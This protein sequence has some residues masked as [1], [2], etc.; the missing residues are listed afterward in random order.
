M[1][2]DPS[3]AA[4]T[5]AFGIQ[6]GSWDEAW[7]RHF[8]LDPA[9]FPE[10]LPAGTPIGS[11]TP[12]A[13][14]ATGLPA[15]AQASVAGHDHICAL[16]A[17]G[18][19][20]P[21]P[22]LDSLGTAESLL[23]VVESTTAGTPGAPTLEREFESGL[24]LVP[25][26]LPGR[27][28][29]LGGLSAAGG[30]VEVQ[31]ADP[32]PT[33]IIYFPYLSG[34]GAPCPDQRVRAA[35]VGLSA[36]HSRGDLA[37]AVLE[38]TAYEAEAIRQAAERMMGQAIDEIV[39]VGGGAKNR[40]WLQIKADV[41]G[42]RYQVPALPE[43]TAL[44]A[45]LVAALG[46]GVLSGP[47]EVRCIAAKFR[48]EGQTTVPDAERHQMYRRLYENG[49]ARLQGPLRQVSRDLIGLWGEETARRD[50]GGRTAEA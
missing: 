27:L 6:E 26:V 18:I 24:A 20:E 36:S 40:A 32:D 7:I 48:E 13:Q 22:M 29:W 8:D 5:Y 41:S 1:A 3:L 49:Y 15:A 37:R 43:A 45:A 47:E 50:E 16:L 33:E 31:E 30:S 35:F 9:L 14:A 46:A 19:V 2:T 17:A 10:V 11:I 38:G 23:G 12:E 28:C 25:H 44:G 21:G 34:S 39:V 4:R 42:C